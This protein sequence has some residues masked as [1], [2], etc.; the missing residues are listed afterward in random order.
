[1]VWNAV[2]GSGA[3]LQNQTVSQSMGR[4]VKSD[5]IDRNRVSVREIHGH[6]F[7][8]PGSG[9][10]DGR[11][12]RQCGIQ[13][14]IARGFIA[15]LDLITRH[16][17]LDDNVTTVQFDRRIFE[18][19]EISRSI[20]GKRAGETTL[21]PGQGRTGGLVQGRTA[22]GQCMG[23]CRASAW[24]EDS[25]VI[26]Q[27]LEVGVGRYPPRRITKEGTTLDDLDDVGF[28]QSDVAV[29][30]A[31]ERCGIDVPL[32]AGHDAVPK[33]DIG[34]T[35]A[36]DTS[37]VSSRL[38]VSYSNVVKRHQCGAI[39]RDSAT[40]SIVEQSSRARI[41]TGHVSA[42]RDVGCRDT[43]ARV[44]LVEAPS[45]TEGLVFGD[46]TPN[47]SDIGIGT[48]PE[49]AAAPIALA[50]VLIRQVPADDEVR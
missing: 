12:S 37:P 40:V 1:M 47:Q 23:P 18:S 35:E 39:C 48:V 6:R 38:V 25:P 28:L 24:Q 19:A 5:A 16:V 15:N 10:D 34:A 32:V 41:P 42:E 13:D 11:R 45:V 20:A 9:H 29:G 31:A 50:R 43:G 33:P 3:V 27:R 7:V 21:V 44:L 8:F 36:L 49:T 22:S 4:P 26:G 30:V 14:Q 46:F 2:A 17:Q